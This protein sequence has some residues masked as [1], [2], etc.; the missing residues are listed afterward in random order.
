M[1]YSF[2]IK[3]IWLICLYNPVN[4]VAC[5]QSIYC[6][7]SSLVIIL[8]C[9]D[10]NSV[11]QPIRE[12]DIP[13]IKMADADE[14]NVVVVEVFSKTK[15]S[16]GVIWN[17]FEELE[18][19]SLAEVREQFGIPIFPIGPLHKTSMNTSS[20]QLSPNPVLYDNYGSIVSLRGANGDS[21]GISQQ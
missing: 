15:A 8:I 13:Q 9:A 4:C 20:I 1:I 2:Y 17:T 14:M 6:N 21:L 10:A 5:V 16:S 7:Y 18:V 19:E 12:K 11:L 3:I